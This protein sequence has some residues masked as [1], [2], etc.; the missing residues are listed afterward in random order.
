MVATDMY[1]KSPSMGTGYMGL[2]ENTHF[3][4][5]CLFLPFSFFFT[6]IIIV[7]LLLFHISLLALL[8]L[9]KLILSSWFSLLFIITIY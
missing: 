2:C 7:L 6:I 3:Q 9:H 8:L 4:Q 5:F 1:G